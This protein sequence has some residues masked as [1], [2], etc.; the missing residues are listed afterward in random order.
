MSDQTNAASLCI[1]TNDLNLFLVETY[2][3]KLFRNRVTMSQSFVCTPHNKT[4]HQ[5]TPIKYY[6]FVRLGLSDLVEHHVPNFSRLTRIAKIDLL[7]FGIKLNDQDYNRLNV[8]LT[9]AIQTYIVQTKR[10]LHK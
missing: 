3:L 4:P 8:V 9:K 5:L 7:L 1:D 6:Y 10:F 2:L